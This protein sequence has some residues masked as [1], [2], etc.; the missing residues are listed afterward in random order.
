MS[1]LGLQ[2]LVKQMLVKMHRLLTRWETV[3]MLPSPIRG[4]LRQTSVHLTLLLLHVGQQ[5]QTSLHTTLATLE[6]NLCSFITAT[7]AVNPTTT[8]KP[9]FIQYCSS[10]IWPK[11]TNLCSFNTATLA[12]RPTTT[13]RYS[14]NTTTFACR[15]TPTKIYLFIQ[16]CFS[17]R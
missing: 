7:L 14:Y 13:Y 9:L 17:C 10:C 15:P 16:H 1:P 2:V 3:T 6:S 5:R 11:T 8:D 12:G 4:M